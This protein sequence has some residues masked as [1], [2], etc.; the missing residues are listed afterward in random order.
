MRFLYVLLLP[1]SLFMI[2]LRGAGLTRSISQTAM[3]VTIDQAI[4]ASSTTSSV[5]N[6]RNAVEH[7][8]RPTHT[9]T[10]SNSAAVSVSRISPASLP[11]LL[12]EAD[13]L[14]SLQQWIHVGS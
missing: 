11:F 12:R 7:P 14:G 13:S 8:S 9:S 3:L 6:R 5:P 1:P 4:P 2:L 10:A